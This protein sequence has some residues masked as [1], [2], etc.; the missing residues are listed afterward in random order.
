MRELLSAA[1]PSLTLVACATP[2]T[3][4]PTYTTAELQQEQAAQ[5]KAGS[6]APIYF[7]AKKNYGYKQIEALDDRMKPIAERVQRA[8]GELCDELPKKP[9]DTCIFSITLNSREHALNAHTDGH[10]VVINPA[11]VDF[12]TNDNQLAFVLSHEMGHNVMRHIDKQEH[13]ANYG[14]A[15]GMVGDVFAGMNRVNSKGAFTKLGGQQAA[16]SYS[17]QF[18]AEAD[19]VGLY[20]MARAGHKIEAAPDVWRIMSQAQ[21]DSIY[22]THTHPNNPARTIAMEKTVA[23]IRTKQRSGLPLIPNIRTD[24]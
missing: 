5:A 11:M 6:H 17:P 18:E 10:T 20:I 21:P 7:N 19:Y 12:I 14:I 2:T 15:L 23:E 9:D 1:V 22:V 24:A 13:N 4:N 16:L 8:A 3:D